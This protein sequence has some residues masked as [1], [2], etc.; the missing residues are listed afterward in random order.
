M[1]IT[2][3]ED[4]TTKCEAC[5]DH[6]YVVVEAGDFAKAVRCEAC[7]KVCPSCDGENYTYFTDDRGYS[8]VRPC[9]VCGPLDHRIQTFNHAAIPRKYAHNSTFESFERYVPG[10][11]KEIGNLPKVH[12]KMYNFATS[13]APGDKGFVLTGVAGNG[14]T[15][16]LATVVRYLT[17][18]KGIA[19]RFVEF[20]HLLSELREQ[21]DH[22]LGESKVLAPV[23]EI[24]VLAID[25]LGKGRNTEWQNSII[26]EIISKRYN[27]GRTTIFTTNYP[28]DP[29]SA[30]A[31]A[32]RAEIRR[33][34]T[35]ETLRER[36]GER[37]YSR[38]HEMAD[39]IKVDAPDY[40]VNPT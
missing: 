5:D 31:Q 29:A 32:Q 2:R 34:M 16:L 25:E 3:L 12:L 19:A 21:F 35:Q 6:R 40:R 33:T 1:K 8:F 37:I 14:K 7:F 15:H 11:R 27:L 17:L 36:V 13:F 4:Y 28:I 9:S 30:S 18:E 24:P 10:T 38:L 22:N 39:F 23:I 20:S 26:D